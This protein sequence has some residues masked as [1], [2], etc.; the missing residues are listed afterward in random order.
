MKRV[1][2][3]AQG[4]SEIQFDVTLQPFNKKAL[5]VYAAKMDEA[6][7]VETLGGTTRGA[8]GDYLVRGTQ[9]EF[10]PCR[11]DIFTAIYDPAK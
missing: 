5:V 4:N 9:G 2:R 8:A 10:Y 7:E 1:V 6:F 11:A 3:D